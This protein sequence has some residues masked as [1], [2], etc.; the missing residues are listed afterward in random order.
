MAVKEGDDRVVRGETYWHIGATTILKTIELAVNVILIMAIM[1]SLLPSPGFR[2]TT[3]KYMPGYR[4]ICSW[5]W[6]YRFFN[7]TPLI[8]NG[9]NIV[10]TGLAFLV[11]LTLFFAL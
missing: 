8:F 9:V 1:F 3:S 2:Y 11:T 4:R 7:S 10:G 6:T 5:Q